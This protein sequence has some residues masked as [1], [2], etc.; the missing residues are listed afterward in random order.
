MQWLKTILREA[1]GLFVDD[2]WLAI[3]SIIWLAFV[4]QLLPRLPVPAGWR[5][6][7]LFLGLATILLASVLHRAHRDRAS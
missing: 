2:G 6:V 3:A 1:F 7:I 4:W 5:G